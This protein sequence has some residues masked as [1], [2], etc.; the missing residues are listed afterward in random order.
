MIVGDIANHGAF[1]EAV[2][3]TPPFDCV[4]HTASPFHDNFEDP[5]KGLLDPAIK[6]TTGILE[7]VKKFAPQV[8]R[9]VLTS[10]FAAIVNTESPPRVYSEASWNPITWKEASSDR[11]LAYRGS[12]VGNIPS[13]SGSVLTGFA[14]TS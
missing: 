8:K 3:S 12:K 2:Q 7:A 14:E 5:V 11:S 1:D 6:G 9:V 4:I 13:Y 10:S